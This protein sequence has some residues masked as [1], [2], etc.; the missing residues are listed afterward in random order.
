M[1]MGAIEYWTC[2]LRQEKKQGEIWGTFN[3]ESANPKAGSRIFAVGHA[4]VEDEA[5]RKVVR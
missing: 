4:E 3:V 5:I 1:I 2:W